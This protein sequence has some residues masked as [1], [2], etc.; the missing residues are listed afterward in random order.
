M[1]TSQSAMAGIDFVHFRLRMSSGAC[2]CVAICHQ[3]CR[4]IINDFV[5]KI[6]VTIKRASTLSPTHKT[7]RSRLQ[8]DVHNK[9]SP[10][11]SLGGKHLNSSTKTISTTRKSATEPPTIFIWMNYFYSIVKQTPLQDIVHSDVVRGRAF[12]G[13]GDWSI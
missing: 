3:T 10:Q 11:L 4:R 12:I 13:L 2:F 9:T 5:L 8:L 1:F 7:W 6:T